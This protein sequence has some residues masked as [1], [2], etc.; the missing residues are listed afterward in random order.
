VSYL[1]ACVP[2]L[3][4]QGHAASLFSFSVAGGTTAG[5]VY[6]LEQLRANRGL[7]ARL[8]DRLAWLRGHDHGLTRKV[9]HALVAAIRR[10]I[11]E[12]GVQL[13]E[14]EESFGW[15]LSL[16]RRIPIPVVVRL[17]G[18]WFLNGRANGHPIDAAFQTRVRN[19][20]L[21]LR[22]ADGVTAPSL[23]VLEK[24]RAYYGMALKQ[25][26]VIPN[27][28]PESPASM[29]WDPAQRQRHEILFIG[30]FDRHKGG[31]LIIDAFRQ[32]LTRIPEARL[33][34]VGGDLGVQD[35]SGKTWTI[36]DYTED[37]IPGAW[38]SGQVDWLGRQPHANLFELRRTATLTVV[39]SRYEAFGLTATEAMSQG[40]PL[41][42]TGAG[43]LSEIVQDGV[44]GLVCRPDDPADLAEKLC[45]LTENPSLAERLGRQA[46]VDCRRRYNPDFLAAR[47]AEY[48]QRVIA[49]ANS[50]QSSFSAHQ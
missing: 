16:R 20:G 40:C 32:V 18:P 44:N 12:R 50:G 23:D 2:A 41:V 17:H 38:R 24:T 6:N 5:G 36:R 39:C 15:A 25:A 30:R 34:F 14:I 29:C 43:A 9:C 4:V 7:G 35:D 47:Q 8:L 37:R 13:L 27:S 22:A 10:A 42:V 28:V 49:R 31:D 48:Y 45:C 21:G 3:E 19:E 46:A 26:E 33:R 1:G 11:S